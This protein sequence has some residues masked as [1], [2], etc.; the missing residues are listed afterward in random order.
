MFSA[1]PEKNGL[2]ECEKGECLVSSV[3]LLIMAHGPQMCS[4]MYVMSFIIDWYPSYV[5]V[6]Q[7]NRD[8][9]VTY[10]LAPENF[11]IR[12]YFSSC[13]GGGLRNYTSIKPVGFKK[14]HI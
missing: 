8:V 6:H 10:N 4:F 3:F 13:F 5:E 12:Q 7:E 1:C 11:E 2:E 9:Y 14:K